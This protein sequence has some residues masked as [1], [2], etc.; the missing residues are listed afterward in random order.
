MIN[1]SIEMREEFKR[2]RITVVAND[3][4]TEGSYC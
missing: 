1:E 4:T 3:K 2:K